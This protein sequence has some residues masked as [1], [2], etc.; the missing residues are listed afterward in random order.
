ML[1]RAD[2]KRY[3]GPS[4]PAR[5]ASAVNPAALGFRAWLDGFWRMLGVNDA[6]RGLLGPSRH[7]RVWNAV[8]LAGGEPGNRPEVHASGPVGLM[9]VAIPDLTTMRR[10]QAHRALEVLTTGTPRHTRWAVSGRPIMR[11][12]QRAPTSRTH[13]QSGVA[14]IRQGDPRAMGG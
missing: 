2:Q 12:V 5:P 10:D 8:V 3:E 4:D 7:D 6:L 13:S 11:S 9:D 1:W 14:A